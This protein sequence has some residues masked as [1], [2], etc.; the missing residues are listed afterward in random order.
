MKAMILAAGRGERMRPLTDALPKPLLPVAGQPLIVHHI[1]RLAASG[2]KEIVINVCYRAEQ[3]QQTLG[4]GSQYGVNLTYSYETQALETGGGILQALPLLGEQP[5]I[6][7][8]G[9]IWTDYPFQQLINL[10]LNTYL[11]HLI[12]VNNPLH[13]P[14]GDFY[15][16]HHELVSMGEARLTFAG[17]G[18]YHPA[19][20][21]ECTPGAFRLAPLLASAIAKQQIS[22]E[23]YQGEWIDIGTPERWAQLEQTLIKKYPIPT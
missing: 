8:N 3:L 6:V 21:K 15:L 9:D 10:P 23:H 14:A 4:A 5:F 18:L 11:A 12:L 20:F 17:M 16:H 19:L 1:K 13:H 2:I 22:G 7:L